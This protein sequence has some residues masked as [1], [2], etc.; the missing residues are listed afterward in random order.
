MDYINQHLPKP[1]QFWSQVT[2]TVQ[3]HT[4]EFNYAGNLLNRFEM[5]FYVI[6]GNHDDRD[7]LRL[8]FTKQA[9][10]VESEGKIDYVIEDYISSFNRFGQHLTRKSGW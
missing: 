2:L 10:P 8:T 1:T 4:K 5:H 3:G 6:P 9:C 7:I